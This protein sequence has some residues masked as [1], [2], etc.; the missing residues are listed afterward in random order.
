MLDITHSGFRYI[1]CHA[2]V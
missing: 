1:G 2:L